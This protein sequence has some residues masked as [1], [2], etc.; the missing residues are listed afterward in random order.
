MARE[1]NFDGLV[2]PTHHYGGLAYG[3]VASM[4]HGREVSHPKHAALQ[5]LKKMKRVMDMGIPQAVLPPQPRPHLPTLR[6][7][8]FTGSVG[9]ILS[10]ALDENPELLSTACSASAMWAAN[11]ATV[12]PS[13]DTKDDR[14][15]ITPANLI[16]QD[17]RALEP[18]FTHKF[19]KAIFSNED[20]FR[21][22]EPLPDQPHLVDEGAANH[23]RIAPSHGE[24]GVEIF[25]YGREDED[26]QPTDQYPA[27]QI[28][29]A[30]RAVA[31]QHG[32]NSDRTLFLRQNPDAIDAG[33][34]HN[35][36]S[37]V[38]NEN[39]LFYHARAY[40][41][42]AVLREF[43][44]DHFGDRWFDLSV[45]QNTVP[46]ETSVE[47]YLF[48]SQIVSRANGTMTFIATEGCRENPDVH[49]YLENELLPGDH[50]IT[51]IKYVDVRQS[52]KNGG[53]PAC[54]RL[55]VVV[56]EEEYR[57][58]PNHVLLTP[59][60]FR[61]LVE[62]V[63]I[64]YRETLRFEDLGDGTIYHESRDALADLWDRLR[65]ETVIPFRAYWPE[66]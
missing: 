55:R 30:S 14:L 54:L 31:E 52:M 21:V 25:V 32:L 16:S 17:H 42:P 58:T 34:F 1:I 64:H 53:G 36:V 50:P 24:P 49:D 23:M 8:G 12:S 65:L 56:T 38:S 51:S 61:E 35:D 37:A 41:K 10:N 19:L 13:P 59:G 20:F 28:R 15:H 62:W 3:N 39:L 66:T 60:R 22:H 47:T 6:D 27:R 57:L 33:V 4:E 44:T 18:S 5:G 40:Q 48:N 45:S 29:G 11:A 63:K 7:A 26:E 2:G 43:L 46:L 9:D